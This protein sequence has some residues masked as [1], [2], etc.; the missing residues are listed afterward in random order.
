MNSLLMICQ[1]VLN[2]LTMGGI[3][4]LVSVG[5]TI[6]FGVMK[7]VNFAQ[8]E[9]LVAGMYITWLLNSLLGWPPYA[10]LPFVAVLCFLFGQISFRVVIRPLVGRDGTS[11]I[12]A[13]M[14][15]SFFLISLYQL[16]FSANYWFIQTD[17]AEQNLRIGQI[18]VGMPR[19]IACLLMILV[20][21]LLNIFLKKTDMGKAMRA[22]SENRDVAQMMGVNTKKTYAF[23]FSL[24]TMMAGITGLM[25]TPI[26]FVQ[27]NTGTP[28]KTIAMVI[29]V[30][31]GLGNVGGAVAGAMIAGVVE[32]L[33]G[34]YA[35]PDL[36]PAGAYLMLILVLMFKPAGLFGKGARKA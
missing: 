30:M 17:I 7:V 4:A 2:G 24:G 14:G 19:V 33:L 26:Y 32:S 21:I 16:L 8:G 25:L 1:A 35:S 31:G 27:P 15:L 5:L 20:V 3:Y 29:I 18:A 22:T 13:T 23:A 28:F 6:I 36:A 10:L 12:V 11:F 9:Y 34:T